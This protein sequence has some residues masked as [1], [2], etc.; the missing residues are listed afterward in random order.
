[1]GGGDVARHPLT[2]LMEAADDIAY[3]TA[4]LED[5]FKK[6]LFNLKEFIAYFEH[7]SQA[8][9]KAVLLI[10][11]LKERVEELAMMRAG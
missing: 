8:D 10:E 2:F 3:A 1:M 11:N 4:D 6:Q 7:E 5:A 9:K